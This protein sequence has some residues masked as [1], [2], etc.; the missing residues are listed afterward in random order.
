MAGKAVKAPAELDRYL[1]PEE[2][3][4]LIQR[5]HWIAIIAP[6]SLPFAGMFVLAW[7][8]RVLGPTQG[9][10]FEMALWAWFLIIGWTLWKLFDWYRNLFIVTDRRLLNTYGL[11]TRKVAMMPLAK[12]TD[13]SYVRTMPGK[14]LG[15][16]A[17]RLESAGQDQALTTVK[18]VPHPDETYRRITTEIFRPPARRATDVRPPPGSGSALPVVEPDDVWWRR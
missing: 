18:Y 8:A 6:L 12:V 2:R 15:Y 5:E 3:I 16:G 14:L 9:A 11:I 1:V 10:T 7:F 17:F 13:M 4:V